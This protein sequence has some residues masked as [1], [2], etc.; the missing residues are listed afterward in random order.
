[1]KHGK[2]KHGKAP[3]IKFFSL[4]Q[5]IAGESSQEGFILPS[6]GQQQ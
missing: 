6:E 1:V 3:D 2:A 4:T 5:C